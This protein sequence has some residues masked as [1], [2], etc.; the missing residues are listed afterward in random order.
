MAQALDISLGRGG[1][2][3]RYVFTLDLGLFIKWLW[4]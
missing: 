1:T 2:G 4:G 3:V